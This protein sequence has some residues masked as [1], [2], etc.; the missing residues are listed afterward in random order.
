MQLVTIR[1]AYLAGLRGQDLPALGH[2]PNAC[3]SELHPAWIAGAK[4]RPHAIEK[5]AQVL[6]KT[7]ADIILDACAG[8][9]RQADQQQHDAPDA[10]ERERG[11][12]MPVYN[13]TVREVVY[14]TFKIKAASLEQ[15][16]E[17]YWNIIG[18]HELLED[19]WIDRDSEATE[20][21]SVSETGE[22]AP[23]VAQ[24]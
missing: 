15:A 19:G 3:W 4:A 14:T 7:L 12:A 18:T 6:A 5:Q 8:L 10:R 24:E 1:E 22:D 20:I 21:V 13:V 9:K 16:K 2:L 17:R 11:S 23:E